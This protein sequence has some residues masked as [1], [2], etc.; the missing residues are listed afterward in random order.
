MCQPGGN[1][2]D[3]VPSPPGYQV[4]ELGHKANKLFEKE[5]R[6]T[7]FDL[8]LELRARVDDTPKKSQLGL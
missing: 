2:L 7:L 8:K 3:E 1:S 6:Q 4:D 5:K